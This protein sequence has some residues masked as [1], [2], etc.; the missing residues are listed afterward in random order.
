M[1]RAVCLLTVIALVACTAADA[2]YGGY[3]R[4]GPRRPRRGQQEEYFQPVMHVNLGYGFPNLDRYELAGFYNT[5]MGSIS[6]TGP[7]MGSVDYQ[8]N[9]RMSI[10]VM[11]THGT[12]SAPYYD[13]SNPS[14]TPDFTG[15]LTNTSVMLDLVR[16]LPAGPAIMPYFRTAIGVNIWQQDYTD[17][18]GNTVAD[19]GEPST[20]AYQV[21]FGA[22]FHVSKQAGLFLEAGYGKYILNGGLAFS[23]K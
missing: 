14:N 21:S 3:H 20:L 8:F 16:Y 19:G 5:D 18:S 22:K 11:I 2:Q 4:Y 7:F 9:R 23:F 6:Q 17:V 1:K 13:F 15:H 12:V 10:G